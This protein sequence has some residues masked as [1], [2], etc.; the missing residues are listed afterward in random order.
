M[1]EMRNVIFSETV[2]P[3]LTKIVQETGK[4]QSPPLEKEEIPHKQKSEEVYQD[5]T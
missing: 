3:H 4:V 2:W 5:L 1:L